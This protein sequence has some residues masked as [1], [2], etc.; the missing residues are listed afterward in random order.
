ML[1]AYVVEGRSLKPVSGDLASL[2]GVYWI[3]ICEPTPDEQKAVE[4]ALGI[5]LRLPEE[6]AKFQISTPV[7]SSDGAITLTALLLAGFDLR[8]PQ[9]LTVQFIRT[10]GPLVTVTKGASGGLAWLAQQCDGCVPAGSSD[11]LPRP[12]RPDHRMCHRPA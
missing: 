9:L 4:E 8:R 12:S 1:Q 5:R 11:A 10:K 6:P 3:D 7:R 2:S